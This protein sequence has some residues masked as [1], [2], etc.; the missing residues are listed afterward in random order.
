MPKRF[1]PIVGSQV[2]LGIAIE[3]TPG[4]YVPPTDYIRL[5]A[6]PTIKHD[7][8]RQ[9]QDTANGTLIAGQEYV[10]LDGTV[11]GDVSFPLRADEG[12]PLLATMFKDTVTGAG[13]YTHTLVQRAGVSVSITIQRGGKTVGYAGCVGNKIVLSCAHA[14]AGKAVMTVEGTQWPAD[15]PAL[16]A[17]TFN[18]DNLATYTFSH[19][20]APL[21][22][23]NGATPV[24]STDTWEIT[25]EEKNV[26]DY[27]AGGRGL[28][29]SIIPGNL[30]T[31]YKFEKRF[32]DDY[33]W[34]LFETQMPALATIQAQWVNGARSMTISSSGAY[35][36]TEDITGNIPDKVSETYEVKT[37]QQVDGNLATIVLVNARATP[38]TS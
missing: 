17:P 18:A 8:K 14:A 29:T 37:L 15:L 30:T 13:P 5:D 32:D 4:V 28:P 34:T 10:E 38:Y 31:M 35:Y 25:F 36:P 2:I 33:E 16:V 26:P 27:G 1:S 19:M 20:Q 3:V 23:G 21:L 7:P 24:K 6:M 22:L 12:W 11:V 9:E